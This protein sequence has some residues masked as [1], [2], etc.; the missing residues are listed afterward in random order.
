M[1][2]PAG[3]NDTTRQSKHILCVLK[4]R[5]PTWLQNC[6]GRKLPSLRRTVAFRFQNTMRSFAGSTAQENF[7]ARKDESPQSLHPTTKK[8]GTQA[9]RGIFFRVFCKNPRFFGTGDLG[10]ISVLPERQ[11]AD[12]CRHQS[13]Q[14]RPS[15]CDKLRGCLRDPADRPVLP[16]PWRGRHCGLPCTSSGPPARS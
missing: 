15:P 6:M 13:W 3:A 14:R 5:V 4:P 12:G 2:L 11:P 1:S 16:A 9:P 8:P 10:I 7:L